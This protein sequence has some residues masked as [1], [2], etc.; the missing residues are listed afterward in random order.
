MIRL[1]DLINELKGGGD[2][3]W[4]AG[5]FMTDTAKDDTRYTLVHGMVNGQGSLS[6]LRFG[7]AWIEDGGIVI[8]NSNGKHKKYPKDLFYKVGKIVK[9]DNKYYNQTQTMVWML[10]SKHWG[11]WEMSGNTVKLR[12]DIPDSSPEIGKRRVKIGRD[13]LNKLKNNL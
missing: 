9:S 11:P 3:Y 10:K 1:K 2:C 5:R 8:D 6:G 13:I 12:E 7:H 4:T